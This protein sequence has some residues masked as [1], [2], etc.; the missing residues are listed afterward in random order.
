MDPQLLNAI[1]KINAQ[2]EEVN[3]LTAGMCLNVKIV[4][5]YIVFNIGFY[6]IFNGD[7]MMIH[8]VLLLLVG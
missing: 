6:W 7:G 8:F 5:I 4:R 2:Q 3:K 1:Q